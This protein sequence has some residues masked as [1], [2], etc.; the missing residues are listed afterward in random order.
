MIIVPRMNVSPERALPTTSGVLRPS[1]SMNRTQRASPMRA[2][3]EL[4]DCR[5]RVVVA[6]MPILAKICGE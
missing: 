3:T 4:P 6:S 5:P 1:L 2:M